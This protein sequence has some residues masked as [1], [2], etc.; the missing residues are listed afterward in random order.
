MC[1]IDTDNIIHLVNCIVSENNLMC[2]SSS[3]EDKLSE[4]LLLADRRQTTARLYSSILCWCMSLRVE[5]ARLYSSIL[6]WCMLLRVESARLYSSILCWYMLLRVEYMLLRVESAQLFSSI[7]CWCMSLL[8]DFA[9]FKLSLLRF[10]LGFLC[11]ER[12]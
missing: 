8:V 7:L 3:L 5:S 9:R 6:C 1:R 12:C 10:P 4:Y 2:Y 11:A